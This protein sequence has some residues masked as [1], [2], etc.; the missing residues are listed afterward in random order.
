MFGVLKGFFVDA[1]K[2]VTYTH[3]YEIFSSSRALSITTSDRF[4]LTLS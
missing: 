4:R 3:V 1:G 2:N